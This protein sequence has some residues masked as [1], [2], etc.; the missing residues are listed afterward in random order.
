VVKVLGFIV[1]SLNSITHA[2][3]TAS[4]ALAAV[5]GRGKVGTA[6]EAGA[7]AAAKAGRRVRGTFDS[8]GGQVVTGLFQQPPAFAF[9]GP[10]QAPSSVFAGAAGGVTTTA[11]ANVQPGAVQ[12]NV[13]A[14][15][16][17]KQIA[18]AA[19]AEVVKG[20]NKVFTDASRDLVKPPP[21]QS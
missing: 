20:I 2:A 9:A 16:D 14:S 8:E 1:K 21:G 13:T 3:E 10:Q 6:L 7:A 15:G 17:P 5:T 11:T 4:A 18:Q 12:V 19:N